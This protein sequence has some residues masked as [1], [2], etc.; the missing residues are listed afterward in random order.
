ML[1]TNFQKFFSEIPLGKNSAPNSQLSVSSPHP[2]LPCPLPWLSSVYFSLN[3]ESQARAKPT[4]NPILQVTP[5][6]WPS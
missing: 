4:N 2:L 3:P 1:L 6:D 5:F